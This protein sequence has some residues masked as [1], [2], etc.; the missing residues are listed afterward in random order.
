[1]RFQ[2]RFLPPRTAHSARIS[3]LVLA[4]RQEAQ[5]HTIVVSLCAGEQGSLADEACRR[6]SDSPPQPRDRVSPQSAP[7]ELISTSRR[8]TSAVCSREMESGTARNAAIARSRPTQDPH[9]SNTICAITSC[10]STW[11]QFCETPSKGNRNGFVSPGLR[12]V[13]YDRHTLMK[14]D[15]T[16]HVIEDATQVDARQGA[17]AVVCDLAGDLDYCARRRN[18]RWPSSRRRS[19]SRFLT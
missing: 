15:Q 8:P 14:H 7:G 3:D 11:F 6:G 16:V 13:S 12:V 18:S 2:R 17:V 19:V 1:M 4:R 10:G 9:H 5:R